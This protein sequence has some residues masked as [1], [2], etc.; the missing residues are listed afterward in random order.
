VR[1]VVS[2]GGTGGHIYPALGVAEALRGDEVHFVGTTTGPEARIVP[3]SGFRFHAIPCRKLGGRAGVGT[4]AALATAAW[5]VARAVRLL[6]DLDP[7]V[8]FGTGGYAT[9]PVVLAAAL[10][11]V[12]TMIHEGNS[13]PG[14]TNR[15][16]AR[17]V[18]R[19][20]VSYESAIPYF[21]R[22]RT[23][24][25]GFPVRG[26]IGGGKAERARA[27]HG[28]DSRP[29]LFAFGGSS[30]AESINRAVAGA[31]PLLAPL[32]LQVL[33][34]TGRGTE[35]AEPAA[36][37][38]DWYH[39]VA[40]VEGMADALAAASLVVCRAGAS[41]LAE[42]T[43]AAKPAILV[44]YPFAHA[45]HQTHNARALVAAGAAVLVPDHEL[46][47]PRLAKEVARLLGDPDG[48]ERMA[49]ASQALGRPEAAE[50]LAAELRQLA[51]PAG[52]LKPS[53]RHAA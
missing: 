43:A 8:V 19:I 18:R 50:R 2:G 12:P 15:W 1:I 52:R 29:L 26:A 24:L 46:T 16:L 44:P 39:S 7:D 42:L 11:R 17:V 53:E 23:V 3:A 10:L 36:G 35:H 20:A 22:A 47:G 28:L 21:P 41:T 31:L 33:H 30:G 40:Y 51:T 34:Q 37:G 27:E 49:A 6:R 45:D 4:V 9:G 48:R 13:I 5:G 25:T 14:R 32:G 38:P